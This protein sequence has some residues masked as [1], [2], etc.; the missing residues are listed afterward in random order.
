MKKKLLIAIITIVTVSTLLCGCDDNV[1]VAEVDSAIEDVVLSDSNS[2]TENESIIENSSAEASEQIS[3]TEDSVETESSNNEIVSEAENESESESVSEAT[4]A[5]SQS[6]VSEKPQP[7]QTTPSGENNN[8]SGNTDAS[9]TAQE[10]IC[11]SAEFIGILNAKRAEAG[12][13]PVSLDGNL[14]AMAL[15]EVK[16]LSTNFDGFT[17][18]GNYDRCNRAKSM[19]SS[20]A[21]SVF[22]A[23]YN[24]EGHRR[25]LMDPYLTHI[26]TAYYGNGGYYIFIGNIDED[27]YS[28]D[29]AEQLNQGSISTPTEQVSS[30]D[31][32]GGQSVDTNVT[33]GSTYTP[34]EEERQAAEDA[35]ANW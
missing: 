34:T 16:V 23:W 6:V 22:D 3:E 21:Q 13:S 19:G 18:S 17:P 1:E 14:D 20:N 9:T 4:S 24:S 8:Q 31:V 29:L 35:F 28:R 26:A 30:N 32:G 33:S 27:A 25:A 10:P 15:S 5:E 2:E 12:L 7:Q 11:T